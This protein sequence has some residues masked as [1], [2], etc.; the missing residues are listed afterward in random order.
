MKTLKDLLPTYSLK[1]Q[2]GGDARWVFVAV[3]IR[4]RRF[5]VSLCACWPQ[6]GSG[7]AAKAKRGTPAR[8]TGLLYVVVACGAYGCHLLSGR[9]SKPP[10][11]TTTTTSHT[12]N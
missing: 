12:S 10:A 7:A 2:G 4:L 1:A 5:K 6:S 9:D 8:T 11:T 3:H